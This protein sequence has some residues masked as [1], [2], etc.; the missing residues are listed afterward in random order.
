MFSHDELS[1]QTYDH[2]TIIVQNLPTHYKNDYIA[3]MFSDFGSVV[4]IELPTK[5]LAVESQI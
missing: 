5:N 2:R 3:E 1:Y 4:S